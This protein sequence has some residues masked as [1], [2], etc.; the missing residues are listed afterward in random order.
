[1]TSVRSKK[2]LSLLKS[3]NNNILQDIQDSNEKQIDAFC[4]ETSSNKTKK[5]LASVSGTQFL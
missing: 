1:M 2:I 5:H 3:N 4:N